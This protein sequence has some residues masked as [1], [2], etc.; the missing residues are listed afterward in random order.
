MMA[1]KTRTHKLPYEEYLALL[2][3]MQR[4]E[5]EI[6]D[7][8]RIMSPAP[9]VKRQLI[10]KRLLLI[11]NVLSNSIISALYYQRL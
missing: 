3:A 6:L 9:S 10:V 11:L 7:G 5:Y 2:E 4:Y 8:E 1:T